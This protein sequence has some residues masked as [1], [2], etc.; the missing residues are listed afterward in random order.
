MKLMNVLRFVFP[1]TKMISSG[2]ASSEHSDALIAM[3]RAFLIQNRNKRSIKIFKQY[4][5]DLFHRG[6][7]D[8]IW[9]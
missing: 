7:L 8:I 9:Q 4:A 6:S 3:R 1:E 2:P 5:A